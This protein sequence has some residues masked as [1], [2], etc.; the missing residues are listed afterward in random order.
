MADRDR[1]RDKHRR[2]LDSAATWLWHA[3]SAAESAKKM[4]AR[5]GL[6]LRTNNVEHA[7]YALRSEVREAREQLRRKK[8]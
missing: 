8:S 3:L 4:A 2:A 6:E 5:A 7:V 1:T